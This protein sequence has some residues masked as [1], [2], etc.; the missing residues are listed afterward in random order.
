[1]RRLQVAKVIQKKSYKPA[2]VA[3]KIRAM[4][5]DPSYAHIA[6]AVAHQM[7]REDGV[8]TACDALEKLY[9]KSKAKA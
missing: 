2:K 6:S 3:S 4:L 1:M 9:G 8:D 5:D 7:N